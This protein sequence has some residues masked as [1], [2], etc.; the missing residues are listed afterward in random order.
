[1]N[2]MQK[3]KKALIIVVPLIVVFSIIYFGFYRMSPSDC[4]SSEQYNS[5]TG[6]CYYECST[7][8]DCAAKAK[9]V[10]DEL[11]KYFD[12][13]QTRLGKKDSQTAPTTPTS[14]DSAG[15]LT[16]SFTGSETN[17][18]IYTVQKSLQL[19]P[20]P[21]KED[22]Q[23]WQLF[24]Q[25]AGNDSL[26]RYVQS[27]E[28]F[29]DG[30]NDTAA[31]VWQSQT[32]G[33]WHVNVNAAY[34]ADKKDLIHTMVHEY[35]HIFSLNGSQ[36]DGAVQG[37]CPQLELSEGCAKQDS[38][39]QAFYNQFWREY[40]D[41][42]PQ[43]DGEN[44]DEVADFYSQQPDAFVSEYAATNYTEDWA[45]TWA[46]FVTKAKPKGNALKDRKVSSLY[47]YPALVAE[48]DRIRVAIAKSL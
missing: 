45:E 39:I 34:I 24:A 9:A 35:G 4:T 36:I 22:T 46:T 1:M 33:K 42:A 41:S 7:D 28:V 2:S 6:T 32:A 37:A 17:G 8:E 47:Q 14:S 43:N 16:K 48:R 44:Q 12:G 21:T 40:G 13:S 30:D 15:L 18:K 23:I 5:L 19:K 29:N 27:F 26:T 20:N 25:V 3:Y 31:S 11:N 38:Y 10:E